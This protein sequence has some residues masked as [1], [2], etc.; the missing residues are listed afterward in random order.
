VKK[1]RQDNPGSLVEGRFQ[2]APGMFSFDRID[3]GSRLLADSLPDDIKG[4]AADFCAGWGFLATELVRRARTLSALDVYEAD[5]ESLEAARVNVVGSPDAPRFFWSD[6]LK[7]PAER[8]YDV[9]VMNPPFHQDRA[10]DPELG[11]GLIQAAATAL[12]QG[13][14][15]FMVANRRLPYEDTLTA[16]FSRVVEIARDDSFKVFSAYR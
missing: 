6:L 11:R 8:R 2:T 7:E 3:A 4:A 16:S 5:F 10:A 12:K 9:I 15:L 13:G 14:R 1:F